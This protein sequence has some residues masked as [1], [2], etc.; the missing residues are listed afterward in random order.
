VEG[1]GARIQAARLRLGW[2]QRELAARLEK[3]QMTV[4]RWER[5]EAK[6]AAESLDDLARVLG[7]TADYILGREAPTGTEG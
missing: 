7:V 4:S 2:K 3:D 1:I 6:P 5:G